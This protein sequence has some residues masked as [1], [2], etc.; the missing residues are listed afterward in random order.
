MSPGPTL[1]SVLR[2]RIRARHYS[3]RTAQAYASWVRR[4]VK[5][6]RGRHP[7]DLGEREVRE[8]LT[9]L[10]RDGQVSAS[11]QNQALAALLFLYRDVL[12][13]PTAASIGH[14]HAKRPHRL[15]EVLTRDEVD[16]VLREMT[17]TPRLMA[18]LLY[19]SGMRLMECC[20]LRV[21]DIA[22][23]RG[24]LL[25]RGGKGQRDRVTMLPER[26]QAPLRAHLERVRRQHERDVAAGAGYVWLPNDL[27]NKLGAPAA[28]S[29]PW[30]WVFPATRTYKDEATGERR[31]HW[32]DKSVLQRQV[33]AAGRVARIGKRVGCHVFRHSFATHVLAAGYDIRTVQE[34]LGHR[35]VRTTMIYTHVLNRG[36]L[37]V[38]SPLDLPP[39]GGRGVRRDGG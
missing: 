28:R 15:P 14:L 29:W 16:A 9:H 30:Q 24:E 32:L 12:E 5:Y 11:T 19:G 20:M 37:G 21:K 3:E 7:R 34:L 17:G 23:A 18:L 22:F 4:Y 10:A 39:A 2:D 8:F 36:G 25:I 33:T 35:D 27:R 6:Y 38:R 26:A 13:I 1:L 31:R